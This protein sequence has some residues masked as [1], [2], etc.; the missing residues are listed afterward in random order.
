MT[1]V[2]ALPLSVRLAAEALW[3]A[4]VLVAGLHLYW[5]LG[6]T[7]AVHAASGGEFSEATTGLRVQSALM[8]VVLV[9]AVLVVRARAGLWRAPISDRAVRVAMWV[10]TAAL[11]L[12]AL[13]NVA[14][15]T[16][17]ERFGIGPLVLVL[18]LLS[19][20]VARSGGVHHRIPRSHRTLPTQ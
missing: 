19:L 2:E 7:W 5:T 14:A 17:W 18:A 12:A 10:L 4:L 9:A 15:A 11:A 1:P 3:R 8:V 16:N 20:V 13:V 6:G